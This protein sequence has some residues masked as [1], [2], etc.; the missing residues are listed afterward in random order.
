[1][2]KKRVI[3]VLLYFEGV[4]CISRNFRI[5][6][7]GDINWLLTNYNFS[8]ISCYIDELAILNLDTDTLRKDSFL[9][10]LNIIIKNCFLPISIGGNINCLLDAKILFDYG[11]DKVIIN[12]LFNSNR[13]EIDEIAMTYGEQSIIASIDLKKYNNC[14]HVYTEH[15]KVEAHKNFDN[16]LKENMTMPVGEFLIQSI[17]R[18][19]TGIGLDLGILDYLSFDISKPIILSGGIGNF[20][21]IEEGLCHDKADAVATSNLLNFIGNEFAESRSKIKQSNFS[22]AFWDQTL[23]DKIKK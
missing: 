2:L 9:K 13:D 20:Q 22:L 7:I 23:V 3:F 11:A 8:H 14:Y 6:K 1:M 4:F 17:D 16:Y 21:H 5:Q 12:K 15:G 18:D 10:D 19:G